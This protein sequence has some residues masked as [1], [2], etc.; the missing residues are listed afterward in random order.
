MA[1]KKEKKD[2]KRKEKKD[3]DKKEK[4][5]K[6]KKSHKKKEHHL[7]TSDL[8]VKLLDEY[9]E[10]ALIHGGWEKGQ[11]QPTACR[12]I[13]AVGLFLVQLFAITIVAFKDGTGVLEKQAQDPKTPDQ[14]KGYIDALSVLAVISLVL[15]TVI[16]RIMLEFGSVLIKGLLFFSL[17]IGA[18][19]VTTGSQNVFTAV[20]GIILVLVSLVYGKMVWSRIPFANANLN[21]AIKCLKENFG[22]FYLAFA[23]AL[24]LYIYTLIWLVSVAGAYDLATTCTGAGK[25]QKCSTNNIFIIPYII[26]YIW[27]FQVFLN[28]VMC[29]SAG[30]VCCWW[31]DPEGAHGCISPAT[32]ISFRKALT[33]SFGS[34][35]WGGLFTPYVQ[36]LNEIIN[37]DGDMETGVTECFPQKCVDTFEY[38]VSY[39][40]QWGYIYVGMYGYGFGDASRRVNKMF[41]DRKWE[42]VTSDHLLRN[43]FI[44]CVILIAYIMGEIGKIVADS[45]DFFEAAGK[46]ADFEAQVAGVV[47]G[48]AFGSIV[49]TVITGAILTVIVLFA[50]KPDEFKEH[51]PELHDSMVEA[52]S[53]AYPNLFR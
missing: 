18:I 32:K 36:T 45:S 43:M 51:H 47:I 39:F 5:H 1:K 28:C 30:V 34:V 50:E 2:K 25:T 42:P 53:R 4:K 49:V 40:S 10:E 22:V 16:V 26:A 27:V 31:S 29:L 23:Y 8:E 33:T 37:P 13:L 14:Y 20:I 17:G 46:S 15:G 3:K 35:C 6:K 12:D 41:R 44:I 9:D 38:M 7:D 24:L 52:Y 11:T 19:L 48:Y 21:T